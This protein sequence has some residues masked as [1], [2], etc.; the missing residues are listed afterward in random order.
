MAVLLLGKAVYIAAEKG[1]F[2]A[3]LRRKTSSFPQFEQRMSES[4]YGVKNVD[5]CKHK[6]ENI[7]K[8][9]LHKC[10]IYGKL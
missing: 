1:R 10:T 4:S 7:C 6:N 2:G 5:L 9:L 3:V 8:F